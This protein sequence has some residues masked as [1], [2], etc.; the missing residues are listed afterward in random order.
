MSAEG[1][2][3]DVGWESHEQSHG[4]WLNMPHVVE[5]VVVCTAWSYP[6]WLCLHCRLWLD[7][8]RDCRSASLRFADMVRLRFDRVMWYPD[9]RDVVPQP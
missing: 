4:F 7:A 5:W 9:S 2:F 3:V 8:I 6:G 1:V